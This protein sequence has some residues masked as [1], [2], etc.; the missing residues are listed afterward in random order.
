MI[1]GLLRRQTPLSAAFREDVAVL[2]RGL[3]R[4]PNDWDGKAS[5]L[6]LKEADYNWRQME[7]WGW[8]LELVARKALKGEFRFPGERIGSTSFDLSRRVNWDL[9]GK[10]LDAKDHIC[11]LNDCAA[12]EASTQKYKEHGLVL[13]LCH[14]EYDNKEREFQKWH[15]ELKGGKSDYEKERETRTDNSRYRKNR[16]VL[17]EIRLLHFTEDDLAKLH[18]M[19]QGRNSNGKPRPD[20]YT[21]NLREMDFFTVEKWVYPAPKTP[22]RPGK[23]RKG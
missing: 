18:K 10:A 19:H 16:A 8:Y 17:S 13:G 14:V 15:E 3:A 7:W 2:K 6:E 20:K 22:L 1:R 5:V 21:L 9:K 4:V 12:M 23:P 11:I